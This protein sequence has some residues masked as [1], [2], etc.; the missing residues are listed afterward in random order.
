M[1]GMCQWVVAIPPA[2]QR[3]HLVRLHADHSR[4]GTA[5]MDFAP[6]AQMEEQSPCKR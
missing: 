2:T 3:E 5:E 6:V 1:R 4:K